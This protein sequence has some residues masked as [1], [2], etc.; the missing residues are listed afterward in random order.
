MNNKLLVMGLNDSGKT[1]FAKKLAYTLNCPHLNADE[2]RKQAKDWDFSPKGRIRQC[3]RM[4]DM[5]EAIDGWVVCDFIC[6]T[7]ELRQLFEP[8]LLIWL[9][10]VKHSRYDDTNKMFEQPE[11]FHFQ[12]RNKQDNLYDLAVKQIKSLIMAD[13]STILKN[14]SK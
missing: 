8:G 14:G 12:I 4:K 13:Y 6:P 1:T 3:L 11:W 7:E 5:A 9:N 2:V 10:T